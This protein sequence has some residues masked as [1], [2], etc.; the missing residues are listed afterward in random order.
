MACF[1]VVSS[2]G[3]EEGCEVLL[4]SIIVLPEIG[5]V[6]EGVIER[7]EDAGDAEDVFTCRWLAGRVSSERGE[8]CMICCRYLRELGDRGRCF[9]SRHARLSFW[10]P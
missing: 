4:W 10:E 7:G 9:R 8:I 5:D 1:G 2:A 6:D 3:R